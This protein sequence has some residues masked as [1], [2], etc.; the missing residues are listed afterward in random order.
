MTIIINH[1]NFKAMKTNILFLILCII[2]MSAECN[3]DEVQPDRDKFLGT[4][5]V[6]ETCG[7]GNQ[8]YDIRIDKSSQGGNFI[9]IYNLYDEDL[10]INATVSGSNITIPVQVFEGVTYS[11]SGS[12]SGN[13]LTISFSISE[14]DWDDNCSAMCTK[15]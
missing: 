14:T 7:E 4:Y 1:L 3:K 8:S 5:G 6:V 15:K 12:I 11:G 13:N 9:L 10:T 2:L